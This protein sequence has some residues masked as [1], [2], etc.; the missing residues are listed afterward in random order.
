MH[1]PRQPLEPTCHPRMHRDFPSLSGAHPRHAWGV[2]RVP[3]SDQLVL[4]CEGVGM[5]SSRPT[6]S[7]SAKAPCC[8]VGPHAH[9]VPASRGLVR[10]MLQHGAPP[11]QEVGGR[12]R[13]RHQSSVTLWQDTTVQPC[14][15]RRRRDLRDAWRRG[16]AWTSTRCMGGLRGECRSRPRR[17]TRTRTATARLLMLM[18]RVVLGIVRAMRQVPPAMHAPPPDD[19]AHA[20]HCAWPAWC[21]RRQPDMPLE[22]GSQR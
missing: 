17:P 21:H 9:P 19:C 1:A 12:A 8:M 10:S 18:L 22:Y 3:P 7:Q 4:P 14:P 16:L 5:S 20:G 13:R 2:G 11:D 15:H 6:P